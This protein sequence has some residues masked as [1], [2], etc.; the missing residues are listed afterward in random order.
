MP[1]FKIAQGP[2]KL[3]LKGSLQEHELEVYTNPQKTVYVQIAR[4]EDGKYLDCACEFYKPYVST[5]D[6]NGFV[7]TLPREALIVTKHEQDETNT[8]LLLGSGPISVMW[9]ESIVLE[10][11]DILLKKLE[12]S[13]SLMMDVAKAYDV[14]LKPINDSPIHVSEAFFSMPLM[15]PLLSTNA[16]MTE[17]QP[18]QGGKTLESQAAGHMGALPGEFV[19]G[20]TAN[21]LMVKEP[22]VFFKKTGIFGGRI[23]HRKHLLQ[24]ISE[25]ALF[26]NIPLVIVDW[27]NEFGVMRSP[28]PNAKLLREQKIEGDPIGFPLKEFLP[29][30]NLK[31]ELSMIY[32][33]GLV[34][35][36]GVK[37]QELGNNIIRFLHEHKTSSIDEAKGILRQLPPSETMSPFHIASV[38]RVFTLLDQTF[39]NFF[40]GNN[41]TEEISKS[42]FQS[43]GRVGV[44]R[45]RNVPQKLRNLLVY[46]ILRGVYEMYSRKGVSGRVKSL[47]MI[48][49]AQQLFDYAREPSLARELERLFSQSNTQDVGFLFSAPH[50]IDFP[51]NILLL[52]EAKLSVVGGRDAGV[53]LAGRKNYRATMRETYSQ[54][55]VKDFFA[56]GE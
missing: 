20:T 55:V 8:F 18:T 44:L 38:I 40:T 4:Q 15:V 10:Q 39:P 28:N 45:M 31:L 54:P 7:Q 48:P 11:T 35:A 6:V 32:P 34:E 42:W 25:G 19:L 33:E 53:T 21:G 51:K 56:K 30:E 22:I 46:T 17:N 14:T 9:E 49:E 24:V 2:W 43:I 50:E 41:P 36:L 37:D 52:M 5:G 26:S 23:E 47:I 13:T 29:G 27:E 3:L 12:V 1:L 16:H